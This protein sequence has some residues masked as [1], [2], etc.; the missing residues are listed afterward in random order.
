M[1]LLMLIFIVASI[2]KGHKVILTLSSLDIR[3]RFCHKI[4]SNSYN[5]DLLIKY[6]GLNLNLHLFIASFTISRK[7]IKSINLIFHL[8]M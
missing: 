2:S 5:V 7:S 8:T 6:Y 3:L 1:F 4:L